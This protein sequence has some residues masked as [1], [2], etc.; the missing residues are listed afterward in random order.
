VSSRHIA[1]ENFY[2]A[3][4]YSVVQIPALRLAGNLKDSAQRVKLSGS[5]RATA[6]DLR[7]IS[8][9]FP[10]TKN[11]LPITASL[12]LN[13]TINSLNISNL[14][15]KTAKK[16]KISAQALLEGLPDIKNA[17][18][19][20]KINALHT[21]AGDI[22][23]LDSIFGLQKL[24][25][26][27]RYLAA[28]DSIGGSAEWAGNATD[29][30]ASLHLVSKAGTIA[31][32][33]LYTTAPD[34]AAQLQCRI[35][36][37][38]IRMNRL[39]A[40]TDAGLLTFG[41]NID[42][43]FPRKKDWQVYL[44]TNIVHAEYKTYVHKGFQANGTLT[45]QGLRWFA[46]NT[47]P[48]CDFEARG[49]FAFGAQPQYRFRVNLKNANL[50]KLGLTPND[51][52]STLGFNARVRFSGTTTDD[53]GGSVELADI[54][55][56]TESTNIVSASAK[57]DLAQDKNLRSIV[58]ASDLMDAEA[59]S[60]LAWSE[61]P[62][63]A[64]MFVQNNFPAYRKTDTTNITN[65]SRTTPASDDSFR[66][67]ATLKNSEAAKIFSPNLKIM[68]G[69]TIKAALGSQNATLDVVSD[70]LG[71]KNIVLNNVKINI[72]PH[73]QGA[74]SIAMTSGQ[75]LLGNVGADSIRTAA[76]LYSGG[77]L[78]QLT[79]YTA[80]TPHK[81]NA[82]VYFRLDGD[83][84][85]MADISISPSEISFGQIMWNMQQSRIQIGKGNFVVHN[86][87]LE[88]QRQY[89][90]L[91][92]NLSV[93]HSD[94]L[95]LTL[96]N[97]DVE[98]FLELTGKNTRLTG[99]L[100]GSAAVKN[101]FKQ[102]QTRVLADITANN[103]TYDH[104]EIGD[105]RLTAHNA[106]QSSDINLAV[107]VVK[108]QQTTLDARAVWTNDDKIN[109]SADFRNA[110][111]YFL[112]PLLE[113]V[114]SN[115]HGTGTGH[116]AISGVPKHILLNGQL[117]IKDCHFVIPYLNAKFIA[118]DNT[119]FD[120]ENSNLLMK[121]INVRDPK[122][123]PA[124]LRG[125]YNNITTPKD[126]YYN[127]DITTTNGM[128]LNTNEL[129]NSTYYGIGYGTGSVKINGKP[130]QCHIA[131]NADVNAGSVINFSL[132]KK[133]GSGAIPLITFVPTKNP[134]A[135]AKPAASTEISTDLS[136]DI[137][138]KIPPVATA[139]V[140]LNAN[141]DAISVNGDGNIKIEALTQKNIL[142]VFGVYTIHS[143]EY[144][145]SVENLLS[146][147]FKIEQGSRVVFNGPIEK[148]AMH[149]T[150]DYKLRA[151]LSDL[152]GDSTTRYRLP[153][154]IECKAII[155]GALT[156]P[157]INFTIT[158]PDA[159]NETQAR[160]QTHFT[161]DNNVQLQFFSLLLT[162]R[163]MP[164]A[165]P[166]ETTMTIDLSGFISDAFASM[167]GM[168]VSQLINVD[169]NFNLRNR[170]DM[171]G[172]S[173][174]STTVSREFGSRLL[175]S[176]TLDY[177]S[178]RQTV[179]AVSTP[180]SGNVDLEVV[181]DKSGKLRVRL[182]GRTNDQYSE[183]L[184]GIANNAGSGGLGVVYQEDFNNFGE[185]WNNLFGKKKKKK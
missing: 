39:F 101:L 6:L 145:V 141:G 22:I 28:V 80:S 19:T 1:V 85:K 147:K 90:Q 33:A 180:V 45:P 150:T 114:F 81:T 95:A 134:A 36:A 106:Q 49:N 128:A 68:Q 130:R 165:T 17:A 40:T 94:S 18:C 135:T 159:D 97:I 98:P 88:N 170:P 73:Q 155:T 51:S 79:Y 57:I 20:L 15:I 9:F 113:K 53:I 184:S 108:Q 35:D 158:A 2:A 71:W 34:S 92:G 160:M 56:V 137:N 142:R 78:T 11:E 132:A 91:Q 167:M 173:G 111:L 46:T 122:G 54:H 178:T 29:F 127:I 62:A 163:F 65:T 83:G 172:Y 31:A 109:G 144:A 123:N 96:K 24:G 100:S 4:E 112:E 166:G 103:M 72:T 30:T 52:V 64:D 77:L 105:I 116:I 67:R 146:K 161:A 110:E 183:M 27:R 50:A 179:N 148:A 13:G 156:A 32:N 66:F 25:S 125:D 121:D 143:G 139:N 87:I 151:P 171:S 169:V 61:I 86:F 21:T 102:E 74:H 93:M 12:S 60:T 162:G 48:N 26:Y 126:F 176:A 84:E 69:T 177:E 104:K 75:L 152:F 119:L 14:Q 70:G 136:V 168:V 174:S 153:T 99:T 117:N 138:F 175:F 89:L 140:M 115:I 124:H 44:K 157:A 23:L 5:I 41:G 185:L 16:T 82:H 42:G 59:A 76:T 133:G 55:Y 120:F 129:Q 38:N 10:T 164:P 149:I 7:T 37:K 58:L 118:A 8:Y 182:F 47:D 43:I 131:V 154:N 3:D 107:S 181:V 63:L